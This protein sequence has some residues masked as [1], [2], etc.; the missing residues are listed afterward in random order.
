MSKKILITGSKGFVGTHLVRK[1]TQQGIAKIEFNPQTKIWRRDEYEA[2]L[3][4]VTSKE[5][6]GAVIHLGALASTRIKDKDLLYGFNYEAVKSIAKFCM[7]HQ[8]ALIF[9]SSSAVYGNSG[10]NLSEYART[11]LLAEE[12]LKSNNNLRV[13]IVRL[14]NTYGFNEIHKGPMK[15]IVSEMI[16]SSIK[17]QEIEIWK[18]PNLEFGQQ[19]RDFI[20]VEDVVNTLLHLIAD[21]SLT[22]Q[23]IDLGTGE[24]TSFIDLATC[25]ASQSKDVKI[26]PTHVPTDYNEENYQVYTIADTGWKVNCPGL[27]VSTK[28]Y[29]AIPKLFTLYRNKLIY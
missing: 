7:E 11:K 24:S 21:T 17:K 19:S 15:S 29:E 9:I 10:R 6:V 25:I 18:L 1:F 26:V 8:I 2:E 20:Y 22:S 5:D 23:T 3:E 14:F 13:N 28:I 4:L 12:Y 16:I 27:K